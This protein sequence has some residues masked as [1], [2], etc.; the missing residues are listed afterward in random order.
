MENYR[1]S[2]AL[3]LAQ[4]IFNPSP[5]VS[6]SR[7]MICLENVGFPLSLRN[8]SVCSACLFARLVVPLFAIRSLI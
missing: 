3:P 5:G 4:S 2:Q 8:S 7:S 6:L 1:D